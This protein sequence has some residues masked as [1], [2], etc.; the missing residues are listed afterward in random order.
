LV[1]K[2]TIDLGTNLWCVPLSQWGI[3]ALRVG[4]PL[5]YGNAKLGVCMACGCKNCVTIGQELVRCRECSVVS[6]IV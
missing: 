3:F 6:R 5:G 2:V 4:K 1:P